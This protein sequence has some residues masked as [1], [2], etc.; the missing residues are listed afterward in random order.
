MLRSITSSV[1]WRSPLKGPE[2]ATRICISCRTRHRGGI[3]ID[4]EHIS[5]VPEEWKNVSQLDNLDP[6]DL[7]PQY[8]HI[9]AL[10]NAPEPVRKIFTLRFGSV[11]EKY[12]AKLLEY[13]EKLQRHKHDHDSS[14]M[15]I[16]R[17]TIGIRKL[18][19]TIARMLYEKK[20]MRIKLQQL[21]EVRTNLLLKLRFNNF[22]RYC[23]VMEVL[24]LNIVFPPEFDVK[25]TPEA[26]NV[27]E[28]KL[29]AFAETQRVKDERERKSKEVEELQSE[30][31]EKLKSGEIVY[32]EDETS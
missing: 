26:K 23:S 32:T 27:A 4:K 12:E 28:M 25:L 6:S 19:E 5:S 22:E 16:A 3:P 20:E 13:G 11:E 24:D 18:Q 29:R 31:L 9:E 7:R 30:I 1:I 21:I 10:K 14:E 8:R 15:K 17:L 2:I